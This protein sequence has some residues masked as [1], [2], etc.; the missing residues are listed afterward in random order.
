MEFLMGLNDSYGTIC[1]QILLMQPL[2]DTHRVYSLLLQQE[3]QVEVSLNHGNMNHHAMLSNQNNKM[4]QANQVKKQKTFLQ[5][6][7][8]DKDY[9]TIEKC[10]YLHRFPVG[11]KLH[12]KNV[13]PP[14]QY[15]SHA[16]NV[17]LEADKVSE[18]GPR[19]TTKEYNQLMSM[20]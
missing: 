4:I 14:N 17:Q 9:H 5:C 15:R 12:G 3:K 1:G 7:Y 11:H 16:N 13:K 19:F 6:C 18:D 20:I 2:P 10:Y 8:C